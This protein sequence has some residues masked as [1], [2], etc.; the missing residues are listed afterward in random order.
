VS[1]PYER[2]VRLK[3]AEVTMICDIR[4]YIQRTI[5][6]FGAYEP[7]DCAFWIERARWSHTIFDV[8]ANVGLYSLLAAAVNPAA[9]V[10]AFE[11][12]PELVHA[13][14]R[15]LRQNAF[16]N[17]IVNDRAVGRQSGTAYLHPCRGS[18]GTNEGMNF[19]SR[20]RSGDALSVGTVSLDDYCARGR[21]QRID[22]LKLDVEGGELDALVGSR[23]LLARGAI[24]C[25]MLELV[26]WA[27][28]RSGTTFGSSVELLRSFGYDIY[29]NDRSL[30]LPVSDEAAVNGRNVVA[31]RRDRR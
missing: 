12:T 14:S 27:A 7:E 16:Q 1:A 28:E 26:D 25:I 5:Y 11:P 8:G 29:A 31:L 20:A 24:E 21:I 2:E 6:L 22:L 3:Q 18:D 17:V 30:L 4:H 9:N 15:N 13:F 19:V 23:D 10:H